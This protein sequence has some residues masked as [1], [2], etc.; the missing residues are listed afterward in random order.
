MSSLY[1]FAKRI[2]LVRVF[3]CHQ[4]TFV[5]DIISYAAGARCHWQVFNPPAP[6]APTESPLRFGILGAAN[7]APIALILPVKNHPDAI[8]KA[9]AARDQG[10]ADAFA[11]KHGIPKAYGGPGAYQSTS[12]AYT[13]IYPCHCTYYQMKNYWMILKLMSFTTP[14]VRAFSLPS[15]RL[16]SCR[17]VVA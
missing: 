1:G 7:I 2:Y 16:K 9:V 17:V 14:Y 11:K 10:R 4:R 6:E 15:P 8:V 13:T 3:L 12:V 5:A